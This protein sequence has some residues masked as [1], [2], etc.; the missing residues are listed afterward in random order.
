MSGS[1]VKAPAIR[2]DGL[3]LEEHRAFQER[4]WSL[5]R[6]AW[7]LFGLL[8]LAALLGLTGSGGPLS[9]AQVALEGGTI[10]Y[11]RI[12]R[13]EAADEVIVRFAPGAEQ[14]R[15]TLSSGFADALQIEGIQPEPESSAAGA[16]G[17]VLTFA[18][19][20]GEA[21]EV[22]IHVTP[23]QPGYSTFAVQIDDGAPETL[24]VLAL[25]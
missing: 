24:G 8:L 3:Q 4:F 21:A 19:A 12:A 16:D 10:D 15:L 2:D 25:P 7:V 9:R 14:H 6:V 22:T 23:L 1:Q 11:P 18:T 17:A 20:A 5:Q 13:W